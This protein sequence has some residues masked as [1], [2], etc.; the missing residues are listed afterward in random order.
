MK[1]A[2]VPATLLR[3][4]RETAQMIFQRFAALAIL[5]EDALYAQDGLPNLKEADI[6]GVA[7][8]V[9]TLRMPVNGEKGVVDKDLRFEGYENLFACDNY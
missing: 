2:P 9:G 5:G 6:G 8:E 7:R 4:A 1:R 3:E